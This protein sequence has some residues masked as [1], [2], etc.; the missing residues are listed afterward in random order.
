MHDSGL[1]APERTAPAVEGLAY[2][3]DFLEPGEE[4]ALLA[5]IAALALKEAPYREYSSKRRIASFGFE[6]DFSARKLKEGETPPGFLGSLKEK[7]I[8]WTGLPDFPHALVT[9]YRPGTPL[10]WHRDTPEF[11]VVCGVSLLGPARMRFRR[12]PPAKGAKVLNLEL[13]ARSA[14]CMRGDARWGWQHSIAPTAALR[15]SITFRTLREA[16]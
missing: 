8:Q 7:I 12:Y 15:Y 5:G 11:G 1:F 14:Y 13:A 6:Y 4:A 2:A 9:E 10:G 3:P 16:A